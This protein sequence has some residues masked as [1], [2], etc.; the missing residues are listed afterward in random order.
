MEGD[1]E[2]WNAKWRV[3][4]GELE[5]AS[6]FLVA[7]APL[8]P[9]RGK[10][11]DLAGGA[12]RN[13]VWLARRGLDVT[14]VDISDVALDKAERKAAEANLTNRLRVYHLD[15]ETPLPFA[16]LFD[17]VLV[18]NYLDR[19]RRD[20]FARLLVEGGLLV[21]SHPTSGSY[22]VG[23]AELDDWVK[24]LGF[25]LLAKHEADGEA[26]IIARRVAPDPEVDPD[27]P[28]ASDGPYR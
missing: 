18:M 7:N 20:E 16:P 2:R 8:F 1:R 4:A 9:L 19:E 11:L 10:A 17:V 3:R 26:A 14:L 6:S 27:E 21:A 28:S 5:T 25:E 15:L 22:A 24:H 12:G 23:I 13:A